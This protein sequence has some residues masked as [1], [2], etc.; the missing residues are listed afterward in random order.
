MNKVNDHINYT[1]SGYR[2][3]HE[4][5]KAYKVFIRSNG[6]HEYTPLPVNQEQ[7]VEIGN[8]YIC[9]GKESA[10]ALMKQLDRAYQKKPRL[11]VTYGFKDAR[12]SSQYHYT[13][14]LC[15]KPDAPLI[16]RARLYNE[17]KD[18]LARGNAVTVTECSLDGHYRPIKKRETKDCCKVN[19]D[20]ASPVRV[21][22]RLVD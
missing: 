18:C 13:S 10:V 4:S 20:L 9:K 8:T 17:F 5:F 21:Y 7:L 16:E 2:Y 6:Q 11:F 12:D 15:C 1:C 3:A 14:Q 19:A 22:L